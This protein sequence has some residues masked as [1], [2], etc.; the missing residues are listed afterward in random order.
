M[1]AFSHY[2]FLYLCLHVS[3]PVCTRLH[4]YEYTLIYICTC[5]CICTCMR[6]CAFVDVSMRMYMC[7][8]VCVYEC[9]TSGLYLYTCIYI[10]IH[11][12]THKT[13][14]T[15]SLLHTYGNQRIH[16]LVLPR[17]ETRQTF[18]QASENAWA[19]LKQAE[20]RHQSPRII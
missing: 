7:I 19:D 1:N 5:T 6:V 17:H 10:Y 18:P 4:V 20:V 14:A 11:T 8:C 15:S 9:S 2:V 3:P 16:V 13:V 12:R